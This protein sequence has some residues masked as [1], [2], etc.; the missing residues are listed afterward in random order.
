MY[1][2]QGIVKQNSLKLHKVLESLNRPFELVLVDDASKDH[3]FK[4]AK[5]LEKK[6]SH[7]RALHF[8]DG[9]SRRE[10]LGK[11][12]KTAKFPLV[13]YIDLDMAVDLKHVSELVRY[14]DQGNKIAIGSRYKGVKAKREL[15]R[16]IISTAYNGLIGLFLGSKIKDHQCGFKGFERKTLFALLK[17]MGIDKTQDRGWFWDAE[18]LIRAQKKHILIIEFPVSWTYRKESSFNVKRELRMIKYLMRTRFK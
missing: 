8:S 7:I 11:A 12:M 17:D 4:I 1:N 14:L 2:E 6:H 13:A 16:K 3:T 10:N 9:P 18:L 15:R 5:E